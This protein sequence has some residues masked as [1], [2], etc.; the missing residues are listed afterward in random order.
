MPQNRFSVRTESNVV[1][2][3]SDSQ[4]LAV[5]VCAAHNTAL[6]VEPTQQGRTIIEGTGG[7]QGGGRCPC[8][9]SCAFS[10]RCWTSAHQ[11]D[12][13]PSLE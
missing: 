4:A 7:A 8:A 6:M 2:Y 5:A 9:R 10:D 1:V 3:S 12:V 11:R 13:A